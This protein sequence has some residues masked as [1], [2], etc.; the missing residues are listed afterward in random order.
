MPTRYV[1]I[2]VA[3]SAMLSLY[4][5]RLNINI[6]IISMVNYTAIPHIHHNLS[7]TECGEQNATEH[8]S[9]PTAVLEYLTK[10]IKS[11]IQLDLN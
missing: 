5:L 6:V 7:V 1:L 4:M 8:S 2:L 11:E 9:E 10:S 3:S